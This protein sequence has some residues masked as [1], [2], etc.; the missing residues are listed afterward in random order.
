MAIRKALSK[1]TRFEVF[2]RDSF[3]C[4]YCG[5]KAPEIILHLDHIK[6]VSKGG[7]NSILNLLTSCLD[8]NSGKSNRTLNDKSVIE[9]QHQQLEELNNR[10]EQLE[11]LLKWRDSLNDFTEDQVDKI[12]IYLEANIPGYTIT[13]GFKLSVKSWIKKYP[14]ES[15]FDSID[16]SAS[17]YIFYTKDKIDKESAE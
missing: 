14:L 2:K 8:C 1:K 16:E 11:M 13:D 12:V 6:P 7:D 3:T 10:R 15:I 9:K 4:Q 17:R 5:R